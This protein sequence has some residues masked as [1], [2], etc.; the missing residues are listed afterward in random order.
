MNLYSDLTYT[1]LRSKKSKKS[2]LFTTV[3]ILICNQI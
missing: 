2:A 1:V 3:C